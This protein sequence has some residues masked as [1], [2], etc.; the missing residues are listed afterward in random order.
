VRTCRL[1]ALALED[2]AAWIERYRRRWEARFAALDE[3]VAELT[4]KEK[5]D[6]R[7]ER[8]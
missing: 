5:A 8:S 6:G 7:D 2:E 4:R 3:V 1:G